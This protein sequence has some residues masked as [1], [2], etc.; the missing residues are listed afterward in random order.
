VT[1]GLEMLRAEAYVRCSKIQI[2]ESGRCSSLD[3]LSSVAEGESS[4]AELEEG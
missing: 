2:S 1:R 3:R 4:R